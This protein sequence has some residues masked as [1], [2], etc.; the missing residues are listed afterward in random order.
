[1]FPNENDDESNETSE[2]SKVNET[3]EKKVFARHKRGTQHLPGLQDEREGTRTEDGGV[4]TCEMDEK[5][6]DEEERVLLIASAESNTNFAESAA[7]CA[8]GTG[9]E[10]EI[11]SESIPALA[12]ATASII[13]APLSVNC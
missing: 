10:D 11:G 5:G 3:E 9:A 7:I 12:L 2:I 1:M 4:R 13:E 6:T 8:A